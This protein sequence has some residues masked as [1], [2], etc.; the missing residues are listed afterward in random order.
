M[1]IIR[2]YGVKGGIGKSLW[3][4]L[5]AHASA[6]GVLSGGNKLKTCIIDVDKLQ[7]CFNFA[8]IAKKVEEEKIKQELSLT[9]EERKELYISKRKRLEEWSKKNDTL[10]VMDEFSEKVITDVNERLPYQVF[11]EEPADIDDYDIVIYD[12]PPQYRRDFKDGLILMPT[13]IDTASFLPSYTEYL[14]LK[15]DFTAIL[16][17]NLYND[18]YAD[19]KNIYNTYFQGR[20]YLKERACHQNAYRMGTTVWG[21]FTAIGLAQ[22]RNEFLGVFSDIKQ[23]LSKQAES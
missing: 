20:K 12:Y 14:S 18:K 9:Y 23:I 15:D 6:K 17:P 2:S 10:F 7:S 5:T 22:A 19:Q 11:K 16:I 1:R 4:M 3:A 21:D 8:S 13:R